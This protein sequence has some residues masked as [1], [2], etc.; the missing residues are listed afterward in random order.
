MKL[1]RLLA[2]AVAF[3]LLCAPLIAT[4]P[5]VRF[6]TF[7]GGSGTEYPTVIAVDST[8]ACYIA[9][10]NGSSDLPNARVFGSGAE[11]FVTKISPNGS[12]ILFSAVIAGFQPRAI[13]VDATGQIYLAGF[14]Y[15]SGLLTTNSYQSTSQGKVDAVIAK[16]NAAGDQLLFATYFGGA[17]DDAAFGIAVDPTSGDIWVAGTTASENFPT[18][19]LAYR[20]NAPA[21]ISAF[22]SRFSNDG[23][24][25]KYSTYFGGA[26]GTFGRALA[27]DST[28][29]PVIAGN[30]FAATLPVVGAFQPALGGGED[31]FVTKFS[32]NGL[33]LVFS[34]FLGGSESESISGLGL[35]SSDNV[36]VSGFTYSANFPTNKAVKLFTDAGRNAFVSKLSANGASLL[37]STYL[38]AGLDNDLLGYPNFYGDNGVQIEVGGFAVAPSG[39]VLLTGT[40]QG[41]DSPLLDPLMST[42]SGSADDGF[43]TSLNSDGSVLF[44]TYLGG[45]GVDQLYAA[46]AAVDGSFFLAGLSAPGVILPDFP[47]TPGAAQVSAHLTGFDAFVMKLDTDAPPLAND[48]FASASIITNT[49]ATFIAQTVAATKEVGEPNHGGNAAAK[50]VW[51]R[52][53]APAS[54]KLALTTRDSSFPTVIALYHGAALNNLQPVAAGSTELQQSVTSGETLYIAVDGVNGA[55]GT[56]LLSLVLSLPPND[57]F[58]DRT[59]ITGS[60]ATVFGSNVGSTGEPGDNSPRTVWWK[61]IAPVTG[62]FTVSTLGSSF[63]T[64]LMVYTNLPPQLAVLTYNLFYTN[65]TSRLTFHAQAGAEYSFV[66]FGNE[67]QTGSIQLNLFPAIRPANDD[68]SARIVLTNRNELVTGSDFDAVYEPTEWSLQN[69]AQVPWPSGRVVWWEWI[70]PVDGAAQITTTNSYRIAA[71]GAYPGVTIMFFA[72]T[73]FPTNKDDF[74]V[75]SYNTSTLAPAS[76]YATTV[77][78]GVHYQIGLDGAEWDQPSQFMLKIREIAPPRILAGTGKI[79]AGKFSANAEGNEGG[80]Y[81]VTASTN[82]TDWSPVSTHLAITGQFNFES[83][84]SSPY[85][86]FRV[87]EI[88]NP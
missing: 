40:T 30:T 65:R 58:A 8:G 22:L 10:I 41:T 71:P 44:G 51:Y 69:L 83:P 45:R 43:V 37:Y 85:K 78:A 6:S 66:V 73:N 59:L 61:W 82:L 76:I 81:R 54:G 39:R 12:T 3:S 86:F 15:N 25:L 60:T 64:W 47:T 50:S 13:A 74:L 52:W 38:G 46:A 28:G 77:R 18:T 53:T 32:A 57:N 27:L 29:R 21:N 79:A 14:T 63:E 1:L 49:E 70:A 36:Y 31:A 4:T 75:G 80:D 17:N 24:T 72:G 19:A 11:S 42:T 16:L 68:F 84:I 9:G 33:A 23:K 2:A 67:G 26:G 35:D 62:E 7:Y 5:S 20:T 87:E 56:L 55:S 34:T 88:S 48:A